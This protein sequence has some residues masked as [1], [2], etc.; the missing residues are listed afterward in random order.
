MFG[1]QWKQAGILLWTS[2][3]II[4]LSFFPYKQIIEQIGNWV[5]DL[6]RENSGRREWGCQKSLLIRVWSIFSPFELPFQHSSAVYKRKCCTKSSIMSVGNGK[7]FKTCAFPLICFSPGKKVLFASSWQ[8]FKNI[9]SNVL[10]PS[11]VSPPTTQDHN[12]WPQLSSATPWGFWSTNKFL[13]RVSTNFRF[14]TGT[15]HCPTMSRLSLSPTRMLPAGNLIHNFLVL[16]SCYVIL[17]LCLATTSAT[18]LP[19]QLYQQQQQQQWQLNQ[20]SKIKNEEMIE[21]EFELLDMIDMQFNPAGHEESDKMETDLIL[22]M[23]LVKMDFLRRN[24]KFSR[25]ISGPCSYNNER[26]LSE[27]N[28]DICPFFLLFS[29]WLTTLS[30]TNLSRTIRRSE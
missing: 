4:K 30:K 15:K 3:Q 10:T 1:V 2:S 22:S 20:V 19:L 16:F 26:N 21:S 17:S 27:T 29:L 28:L 7:L 6:R 14:R 24:S 13:F 5:I 12:F 23:E 18:P 11:T 25:M 8:Q 9:K